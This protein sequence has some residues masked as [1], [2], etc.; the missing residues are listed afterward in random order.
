MVKARRE[1]QDADHGS[2]AQS[3]A[4]D[5]SK[6]QG[7]S[8]DS[9]PGPFHVITEQDVRTA[10]L[11]RGCPGCLAPG[12]VETKGWPAPQDCKVLLR[13]LVECRASASAGGG[14]HHY[15]CTYWE[16]YPERTPF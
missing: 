4:G 15:A 16:H 10:H 1:R 13:P 9:S 7:V 12:F 8:S 3:P 5:R 11:E 2:T 6:P 14:Q